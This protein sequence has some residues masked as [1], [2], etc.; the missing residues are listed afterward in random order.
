MIKNNVLEHSETSPDVNLMEPRKK[1]KKKK[2]C[3]RFGCL[4]TL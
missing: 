2:V 4:G 3:Y 1:K